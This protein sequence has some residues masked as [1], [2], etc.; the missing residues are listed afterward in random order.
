MFVTSTAIVFVCSLA[1]AV[2]ADND[3]DNASYDEAHAQ[4]WMTQLD[5]ELSDVMFMATSADWNYEVNLT[6]YNSNKSV[7]IERGLS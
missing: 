2:A 7:R 4:V 1:V 5:K 3:D 6:E